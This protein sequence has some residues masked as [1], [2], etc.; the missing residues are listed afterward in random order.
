MRPAKKTKRSTKGLGVPN[1]RGSAV[2]SRGVWS[3]R[4]YVQ[5]CSTIIIVPDA[6]QCWSSPRSWDISV[7]ISYSRRSNY[8][9]L[10]DLNGAFNSSL[11]IGMSID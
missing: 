2:R 6:V 11:R 7:D 4:T 10:L 8:F 1:I 5:Y 9:M 3:I